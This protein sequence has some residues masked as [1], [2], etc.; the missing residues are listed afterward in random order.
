MIRTY[1]NDFE[2]IF[3]NKEDNAAPVNGDPWALLIDG[4]EFL[5]PRRYDYPQS[6][7][8]GYGKPGI[9]IADGCISWLVKDHQACKP[10]Y[11]SPIFSQ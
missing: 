8:T 9:C 3:L 4:E 5:K 2:M 7:K 10:S 6:G 11:Q 1:N